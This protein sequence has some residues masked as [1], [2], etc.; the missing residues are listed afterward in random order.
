MSLLTQKDQDICMPQCLVNELIV[1][2]VVLK[3][4]GQTT[5]TSEAFVVITCGTELYY[6]VNAD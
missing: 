5:D 4:V 6:N 3:S 2:K 1:H